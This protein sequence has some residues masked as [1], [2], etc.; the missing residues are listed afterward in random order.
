MFSVTCQRAVT[1]KPSCFYIFCYATVRVGRAGRR[2]E[3]QP[4]H[5]NTT[6]SLEIRGKDRNK[7]PSQGRR[8]IKMLQKA[9]TLRTAEQWRLRLHSV[10]KQHLC[11]VIF[12]HGCLNYTN[13]FRDLQRIK[14]SDSVTLA[15]N[16]NGFVPVKIGTHIHI[17]MRIKSNN[18][19]HFFTNKT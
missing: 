13:C 1:H 5:P 2:G 11:N 7:P 16:T 8:A 18:I 15:N 3:G 12:Q 4:P 17:G 10:Y 14:P 6:Q 19:V 9:V